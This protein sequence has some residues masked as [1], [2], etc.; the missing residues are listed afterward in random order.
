MKTKKLYIAHRTEKKT[1]AEYNYTYV[2]LATSKREA[3]LEI[4][5]REG[6]KFGKRILIEDIELIRDGYFKSEVTRRLE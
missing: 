6:L 5:D 3:S 1:Y 2:V 4:N